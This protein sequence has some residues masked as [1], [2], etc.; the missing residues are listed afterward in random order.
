MNDNSNCATLILHTRNR[1]SFVLRA[2]T[3]YNNKNCKSINEYIVVDASDSRNY[4]KF[5]TSFNAVKWNI[6]IKVVHF[7]SSVSIAPRILSAL[8]LTKSRY[9]IL[10]ADDDLF[11]LDW[12]EKSIC[13]LNSDDSYGV[14]YGHVV[15]F[16]LN[17]YKSTGE[18][19]SYSISS[20]HR[21][22]PERWLED[23]DYTKRLSELGKSDWAT[24]GWYAL[25]R[26]EVLSLIVEEAVRAN[27]EWG[28]F[29]SLMTFCQAALTKTRKIDEIIL[30]RQD[31]DRERKPICYSDVK[32]DIAILKTVCIKILHSQLGV[33]LDLGASMVDRAMEPVVESLKMNESHKWSR[34]VRLCLNKMNLSSLVGLIRKL[35]GPSREY[36]VDRDQRFPVE[37]L[38]N[39]NS[40]V[41]LEIIK[42]TK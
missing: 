12:I 32:Y 4:Q 23:D 41:I 11:F 39:A 33:S 30:A 6:R 22:P 27:I 5:I 21:I 40:P 34:S 16:A 15:R 20:Q 10:A 18:L 19:K 1:P 37:P 28:C 31:E 14:V 9:I 3:Y 24:V 17:E 36:Y 42:V 26:R 35:R 13:F 25:Q 7:P 29:E 8:D 2:L 38:L